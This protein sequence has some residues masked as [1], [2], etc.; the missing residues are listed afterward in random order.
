M[1]LVRVI[2]GLVV[3]VQS[4]MHD[5]KN[6]E[7]FGG[8]NETTNNRMELKAVIMALKEIHQQTLSLLFTRFYICSEGY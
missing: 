2:L 7:L 3:G 6:I 4:F 5:E 1:E 8:E